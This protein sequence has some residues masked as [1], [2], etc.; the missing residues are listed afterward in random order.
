MT[1]SI[2]IKSFI[3]D[4]LPRATCGI[5]HLD[6]LALHSLV[7]FL[8][9]SSCSAKLAWKDTK[10]LVTLGDSYTTDGMS[11]FFIYMRV[12]TYDMLR[13]QYFGRS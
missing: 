1:Q 9:L 3:V 4:E 13:F 5:Q 8:T 6:M 2:G 7:G 12:G 10:F 11:L